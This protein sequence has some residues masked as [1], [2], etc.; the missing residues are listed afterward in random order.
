[1]IFLT[2]LVS[3]TQRISLFNGGVQ[4]WSWLVSVWFS[5][6]FVDRLGRKP[7]FMIAA[8]GMLVIFSIWTG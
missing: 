8:V 1:M 4:I 7:R 5:V 3:Q 6:V 2:E